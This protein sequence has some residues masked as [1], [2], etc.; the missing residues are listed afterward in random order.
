MD[1]GLNDRGTT[2]FPEVGPEV[3]LICRLSGDV[4]QG[5]EMEVLT[6]ELDT[7][8][9]AMIALERVAKRGRASHPQRVGGV[10]EPLA[11]QG[12]ES[13]R[14]EVLRRGQ[15]AFVRRPG[16]RF[17]QASPLR[18]KPFENLN[19]RGFQ[20]HAQV[21]ARGVLVDQPRLPKGS[22]KEQPNRPP[23]EHTEEGHMPQQE[24]P[25]V[26]R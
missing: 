10:F 22:W 8:N 15:V 13:G 4:N 26:H 19:V 14:A 6:R 11:V 24:Q 9:A 17:G 5:R 3:V 20:T 25:E 7:L 21:L 16:T 1:A 12:S 23:E 2:S 18:E